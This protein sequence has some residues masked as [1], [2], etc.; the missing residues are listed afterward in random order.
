M[1]RELPKEVK[2]RPELL[3][4]CRIKWGQYIC[5]GYD[6]V[7][8]PGRRNSIGKGPVVGDGTVCSR[9]CEKASVTGTEMQGAERGRPGWQQ[10]L[11][12]PR[13]LSMPRI[14]AFVLTVGK[15]EVAELV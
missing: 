4:M 8:I 3:N 11:A 15:W 7:G 5:A 14:L 1:D 13:P 12:V 10:I 6:G 9:G 2:L